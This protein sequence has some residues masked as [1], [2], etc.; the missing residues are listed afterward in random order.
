M[1]FAATCLASG[2]ELAFEV[3]GFDPNRPILKAEEQPGDRW[4]SVG[5]DGS[6][7]PVLLRPIKGHEGSYHVVSGAGGKL[8]GLRVHGVKSEAEYRQQ[9]VAKA[10]EKR[11]KER[12]EL[13]KLTPEEQQKRKDEQA[14]KKTGRMEA[15]RQFSTAVLGEAPQIEMP[16]DATPEEIKKVVSTAHRER[17]KLAMKTAKDA[18][19]KILLD[20]DLRMASGLGTSYPKEQGAL[21]M[22]NIDEVMTEKGLAKGPGYNRPIAELAEKNGLTTEALAE[23]VQDIKERSALEQ[24][25]PLPPKG[26]PPGAGIAAGGAES[27][28]QNQKV[29]SQ[30]KALQANQ[31]EAIRKAIEESVQ[32][33]VQLG[34][35]LKARAV[36]RDAYREAS[37]QA[38]GRVFEPGFQMV[39]G[40][41]DMDHIVDSLEDQYLTGAMKGFLDEVE[42]DHPAEEY[43]DLTDAQSEAGMQGTRGAAAFDALHE[44]ALA[45]LGQGAINRDVVE[46]LGPE[47]AAQVVSRALRQAFTPED[48]GQ[49]LKALEEHHVQDQRESLSTATAEAAGL[50]EKAHAIELELAGSAKDLAVAA[51]MTHNKLEILKEARRTLGGTLGR[52]EARAA[53]IAALKEPP[54]DSMTV[55]MGKMTP[56]RAV[57]TAAALGLKNGEYKIDHVMGEATLTLKADGQDRL[58]APVDQAARGE[59]EIALAIKKGQLDEDG[60]LP[61][62]FSQR[63]SSRYDNPLLEP[64]AL[65]TSL[66]LSEGVSQQEMKAQVRQHVGSRLAEGQRPADVLHDLEFG[67]TATN[68]GPE[69]AAQ[70]AAIAKDGASDH[71]QLVK[72][73]MES[74]GISGDSTFHGQAVDIDH[75]DFR[76]ALHR[77]LADDPRSRAAH[78]PDG[79]LSKAHEADLKDYYTREMAKVEPGAVTDAGAKSKAMEALGPEPDKFDLSGSAMDDLGMDP[80]P[81]KEWKAWDSKRRQVERDH[82]AGAVAWRQLVDTHQ[83]LKGAYAA[84]RH[85]MAGSLAERFAQHYQDVTG[86]KLRVGDMDGRKGLGMSLE[87]QLRA[88]MPD[89]AKPFEGM[90][91]GVKLAKGVSMAGK[92]VFQQRASK[93]FVNLKRMGLYAGAGCVHGDT[94]L[95]CERTGK[96]Q[97]FYEWW[98]SQERPTVR[99]LHRDGIVVEKEA[100]SVFV[101]GYG[102]MLRVSCDN[103][104]EIVVTPGHRFFGDSGWVEAGSLVPGDRLAADSLSI[105][106]STGSDGYSQLRHASDDLR[107]SIPSVGHLH[108]PSDQSCVAVLF[109]YAHRSILAAEHSGKPGESSLCPL[110]SSLGLSPSA[111]PEDGPDCLSRVQDYQS[112]CSPDD[113]PCDERPRKARGNAQ[114][115]SPSRVGAHGHT[116]QN[117]HEGVAGC[118]STHTPACRQ[119]CHRSKTDSEI[120]GKSLACDVRSRV[121]SCI[122]EQ[123]RYLHRNAVRFEQDS[124]PHRDTSDA[125]LRRTQASSSASDPFVTVLSVEPVGDH[126]VFDIS[127]HGTQNYMAQGLVNHNSGKTAIMLG[128]VANLHAAGKLK[129]CIMAVPSVVQAQFGG[130]A[131]KFLDPA[132]GIRVHARPGETFEQRLAAYKDPEKHAVVVTHQGLRDDTMK[133]LGKHRGLEGDAL[134]QFVMSTPGKELSTAVK[135]AFAAEGIDYNAMMVDEAHNILSRKGK[136]DASMTKL[137]DAHGHAAEYHILATGNPIRNDAS[138]AW[139]MLH[140]TDPVRYPEGSRDEF[141]ARFGVDTALARRSLKQEISRYFFADRV[142]PGVAANHK[143]VSVTLGASQL[144]A[145]QEVDRAAAKL[146]TGD[147]DVVKWAKVLSPRSFDGKD[148]SLH[149][150][151]ADGV[152]KASGTFRESRLN[153]IINAHPED[154]AKVAK[155]VELAQHHV[156]KGEPTVIFAHRMGSVALLEQQLKEAGLKV[157]TLTGKDS[158]AGKDAKAAQF[159]GGPGKQPEAD[160]FV[161]SDAASTGLNLQ[162]GKALIHLDTPDTHLTHEQRTARIHRLGQTQD[163]SVYDLIADHPYERKAQERLKRKAALTR[164]FQDPTGYTDDEGFAST[165]RK[166]KARAEQ[167]TEEDV[168]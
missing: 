147:P 130:E 133:L 60:Y 56:Q 121:D 162:R 168:A 69:M 145:V 18:E 106:R 83:G 103:G 158:G 157:A 24:G 20:A 96:T 85:E 137:L 59:R 154:N 155:A 71:A 46:V 105:G 47:G 120:Q 127:V 64:P 111:H 134:H 66:E 34:E 156:G 163:V 27:F 132:S 22:V 119:S 52:L 38:T 32:A 16:A 65:Q 75:P 13:A 89:A 2:E 88:A 62:G 40:E 153:A 12:E 78:I 101:K 58:I 79:E 144:G 131:A 36:L 10:K 74:S 91:K 115:H 122:D 53:L 76:E 72:E 116:L 126:V 129:K 164:I 166:I 160:V 50:R 35:V 1:I 17:L 21:G 152:K 93:A 48:Q 159:M 112:N 63:T 107:R 104:S 7:H 161:L 49:I 55:P 118:G 51:E 114:W 61:H 54:R 128:G 41:P 90:T 148:E 136:E 123:T 43:L 39:L 4:I 68:L 9:S 102:A 135:E 95:K 110:G 97:S 44:V 99:S 15:E 86:T 5:Q 73:F 19:K 108:S 25:K 30:V 82:D 31:Q 139:G 84:I 42:R 151:I 3:L 67:N 37:A 33:N 77:T 6:K 165:L 143:K 8:N 100:S 109:A 87:G 142:H 45:T 140:K 124:T 29:Q 117:S 92:F 150:E 11:A 57:Q 14:S 98:L 94:L 70:V 146:R 149:A 23:A 28:D 81:S 138:E 141:M 26:T 125:I 113:H 80:Q 167:G